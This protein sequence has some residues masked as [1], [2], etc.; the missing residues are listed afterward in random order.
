MGLSDEQAFAIDYTVGDEGHTYR[1]P[2][3]PIDHLIATEQW[4]GLFSPTEKCSPDWHCCNNK[5]FL[6][7]RLPIGNTQDITSTAQQAY[8][9]IFEEIQRLGFPYLLR[10]WNFFENITKAQGQT[11]NY[12]LFCKGRAQA[13]QLT[14]LP[15]AC[16]PAAT[17]IGAQEKGLYIYFLAGKQAG[18]GIENN[19][20]VSAYEYPTQYSADPPLFSRALL[21]RTP[22]QDCLF[23]SGTASIAGHA[24]Q[25]KGQV[26][27]QL[28]LCIHNVENLLGS[29]H[30]QYQFN[31]T[32][33]D[34]CDQ[35][36]VYVKN[37]SDID[38][39]K[40]Y[41]HTRFEQTLPVTF[42][43]GDMCREDLLVEIEAF[44]S[45]IHT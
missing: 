7:A 23:I 30:Q 39:I 24:T 21:H 35:I 17:V 6:L 43:I 29:A 10:T 2:L 18:I 40:N 14:T 5:Q 25:H 36:K 1:I 27:Q 16:Y 15:T 19:E 44:A 34:G 28:A 9:A 4:S 3:K 38:K 12:Q 11:D 32:T 33:F 41:F 37:H 20:Q 45:H 8:Q 42:F 26:E 22:Q 31:T 13:Y